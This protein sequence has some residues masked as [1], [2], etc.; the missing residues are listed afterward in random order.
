MIGPGSSFK[1]VS[2]RP[3]CTASRFIIAF[4][5]MLPLCA[6]TTPSESPSPAA[7]LAPDPI[8]DKLQH[9]KDD[10]DAQVDTA[11]K[12]LLAY[13]TQRA[14]SAQNRGDLVEL[15]K[16]Q[17]LKSD[18]ETLGALPANHPDLV[19]RDNI[20]TCLTATKLAS[21]N[22]ANAY[23][24]TVREY[25]KA[26]KIPEAEVT[27]TEL[28]AFQG[29][30]PAATAPAKP[31]AP[32]ATPAAAPNPTGNIIGKWFV[33]SA[34]SGIPKY[35]DPA[36]DAQLTSDGLSFP[37]SSFLRTAKTD[38]LNT[39]F[40]FDAVLTV[41]PKSAVKIGLGSGASHQTFAGIEIENGNALFPAVGELGK[42]PAG[43]HFIHLEKKGS[44]L[45]TAIGLNYS[46]RFTPD[47]TRTFD[48]KHN[49]KLT[50]ENTRLFI[51]ASPG[52]FL[53]QVR[54]TIP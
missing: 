31:A 34:D 51:S 36:A 46:T 41:G 53:K 13:F 35:F 19:I 32:A 39:N 20:S 1:E 15:K 4:L 21:K 40:S 43:T 42:I 5:G 49:K 37:A 26:G 22:L 24:A 48:L 2:M 12:H 17:S 8:R 25:T 16:F 9:A 38:F 14:D 29:G 27:Q 6:A 33:F 3:L 45:T 52:V 7:Q 30:T 28:D 47:Y 54:L 50:T 10:Y 11:K 23:A 44:E 18:Y